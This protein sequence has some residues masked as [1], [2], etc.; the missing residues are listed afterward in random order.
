MRPAPRPL[1]ARAPPQTRAPASTQR[2]DC[3][4]P[5]TSSRMPAPGSPAAPEAPPGTSTDPAGG[6][7][8]STSTSPSLDTLLHVT[9]H[10]MPN[11]GSSPRWGGRHKC[12]ARESRA[13]PSHSTQS[14][15]H[16]PPP[17]RAP[18]VL[19]SPSRR[20]S[21]HVAHLWVHRSQHIILA[22]HKHGVGEI[23]GGVF[24]QAWRAA[25]GKVRQRAANC[26]GSCE[27]W[28]ACAARHAR[29]CQSPSDAGLLS[30]PS[31]PSKSYSVRT[32]SPVEPSNT[33]TGG[34]GAQGDAGKAAS[35]LDEALPQRAAGAP[36][37]AAGLRR[38][39]RGVLAADE[40]RA[41]RG[42]GG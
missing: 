10:C 14:T 7:G 37:A 24:G 3:S 33:N 42:C 17:R 31:S 16:Q 26:S 39:T 2:S 41:V 6:M 27:P 15:R 40:Q 8:G 22:P 1:R 5:S 4:A 29:R 25:R 28:A 21:P 18:H 30:T 36:L 32:A 12:V 13:R 11:C 20:L 34:S 23:E 35:Q 19:A 9:F 38:L